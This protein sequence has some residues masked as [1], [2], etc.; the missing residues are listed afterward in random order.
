MFVKFMVTL[1]ERTKVDVSANHFDIAVNQSLNPLAAPGLSTRMQKVKSQK[2]DKEAKIEILS[3]MKLFLLE[4]VNQSEQKLATNMKDI[5]I[6][7]DMLR[8]EKNQNAKQEQMIKQRDNEF[9][10]TREN[11]LE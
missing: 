3:N 8:I 4:K 9:K 1:N 10:E 5:S 11:A 7:K 6:L 2:E